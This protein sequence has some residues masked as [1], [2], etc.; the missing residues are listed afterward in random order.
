[1]P[2]QVNERDLE[3]VQPA[4]SLD[5][6]IL[7]Q[8]EGEEPEVPPLPV[9][10]I[11]A[12]VSLSVVSAAVMTGGVFIGFSPRIY[13]AIA[14]LLGV[15][16]GVRA[17]RS[18]RTAVTHLI[19]AL[20][21][22]F[23]GLAM[24]IPTGFGNVIDMGAHVKEAVR[25]GDIR[26]PPVEFLPG[27]HAIVGWLLGGLG[28]MAAWVALELRKPALSLLIPLP[29]VAITAISVP[30]TGR[31]S[32]QVLSGVISLIFFAASMGML[33]GTQ[34]EGSEEEQ[35]PP[36]AY[37][38]RRA[39][40]AI[41]LMGVIS[42]ALL[43][44]PG[45]LFPKPLYDPTQEAK[46]PQTVPLAEVPDEVLFRVKSR[47]TGP[48]RLGGLDVYDPSD[49][50]WR[51]PPFAQSKLAEV[52]RS[53]VVDSELTP[54]VKAEFEV[55]KLGGAVLPGMPNMV[56]IVASGPRL[57]YDSRNANIRLASG[58]ITEGLR[59]TVVAA[60][61]PS[62]ENLREVNQDPK[63]LDCTKDVKCSEY[64][65]IPPMPPAVRN[66]LNESG[67]TNAWDRLDYLRQ[68]L[69]KTV[70]SAGSGTPVPV[71]PSRVEDM[72]VGSKE[73]TPYEIVAAQ[74]MLARWAGVPSR[75]GYGFDGGEKVEDFFEL[76][77]K[78]GASYL[79][80]Y[81]PTYKWLPVIGTPLKAKT[82]ISNDPQQFNENVAA[83]DEVAVRVFVPVALDPR[84]YLY[85]QIARIL[86]IVVPVVVVML[87]LYYSYPALRKAVVRSRRRA[88]ASHQGPLTRVAVAYADWR[89]VA[90]DFGYKHEADTPLMFLDRV[91]EDEEH[92]QL[93]WLVTRGLWGDLKDA[94]TD[95]DATAA[96]EL[97]KSLRRRLAQAHSVTLRAVAAVSRLSIRFPYAPRLGHQELMRTDESQ[98]A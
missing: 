54:G 97:S 70:T 11:A 71:P 52:P 89:D 13:A 48:W 56:G 83:S 86:G 14:G 85:A 37:E 21:I 66:L 9:R 82:S 90:T 67:A 95:S 39:L 62:I 29:I 8:P 24:V 61:I 6:E 46:K 53:G 55:L 4:E 19:I 38:V 20:G 34:T 65:E 27:W 87:L 60:S 32:N 3:E 69:L 63:A 93:A 2:T 31:P 7:A 88:W 64:L 98:A 78:H 41:P 22:F 81:F 30:D 96:E 23:I 75:I 42:A 25:A 45:I 92:T 15:Y 44:A 80:V 17:H 79:E 74:A 76:R 35:R 28:F 77:P 58:T 1:M 84:N 50:T 73:G 49:S 51:L 72:L 40:R 26:R 43:F 91:V 94:V 16:V 47:V 10:R 59:Y 57:A 12:V 33:S 68:T 18:R 36:M 5:E